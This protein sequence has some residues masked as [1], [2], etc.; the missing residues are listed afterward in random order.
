MFP[1]DLGEIHSHPK[2]GASWEG[3]ALEQVT[4]HLGLSSEEVFFWGTHAEAE[5]DLLTFAKGRAV[6]FEFKYTDAPKITKSM[7]IA[8]QDLKLKKLFVIY[9]GNFNFKLSDTISAIG[10]H[11]IGE[12]EI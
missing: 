4:A 5:L 6:G 7:K 12:L 10:F 3:F 8:I 2:L 9:P 1:I 11:N